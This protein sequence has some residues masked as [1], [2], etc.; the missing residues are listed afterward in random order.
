MNRV[1]E[2]TLLP[3]IIIPAYNESSGI[4]RLLRELTTAGWEARY[5]ILVSCNGCTDDTAVV[6][7]SFAGVICIESD[8]P[9]K[10]KALQRAERRPLGY[11][12]LYVDADVCISQQS[13]LHLIRTL[14]SSDAPLLATPSAVV[15]TS[16]SSLLVR[17]YYRTWLRSRFCLE[18]G[19][20]SGVY[21]LNRAARQQFEEFPLVIADDGFVR[22]LVPAGGI[23]RVDD[24]RSQVQAPLTLSGLLK[25]KTRSK[26]G[27]LQLAAMGFAS[28]H[29]AGSARFPQGKPALPDYLLYVLINMYAALSARWRS[30]QQKT[31]VWQRDESSRGIG[32]K[33]VLAVASKGGHWLQLLRLR[34]VWADQ[35]VHF[36]SNDPQLAHH[37]PGQKFSAVLDASMD[38]KPRLLLLAAQMFWKVLVLRPDVV[39]STGAAPGYFAVLWGRL[40]GAKTV[41]VDSIANAETLSLSGSKV[42]RIV[43]VWLTQ[44]PEVARENGP[45]Y[46]GSVF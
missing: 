10:I 11:P 7:R 9:S 8:E 20:G 38:S 6:V 32:R 1:H 14:Q 36:I 33:R 44:W 2:E 23:V 37:V 13:I 34:Q 15:D 42:G 39:I 24:A 29:G 45:E 40:L 12:R 21:G 18:D 31:Y 5:Q 3:A 4:A 17:R 16:E 41:W 25:I 43:D 27:N 26:L 22:S 46:R 19:Y 28:S 35:D 30:R